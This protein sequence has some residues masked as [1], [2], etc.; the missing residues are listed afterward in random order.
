MA[1]NN[2]NDLVSKELII[3]CSGTG[4]TTQLAVEKAFVEM[5]RNVLEQIKDP[6]VSLDTNRVEVLDLQEHSKTE[7]YL[8]VFFKRENKSYT[9]QLKVYINVKYLSLEGRNT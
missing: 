5:R 7:A 8:G 3:E 6:I 4:E 9:I 1:N 2:A